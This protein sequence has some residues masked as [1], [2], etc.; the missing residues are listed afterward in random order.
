MGHE[1]KS[2]KTFDSY[3][4]ESVRYFNRHPNLDAQTSGEQISLKKFQKF[5]AVF[6][7]GFAL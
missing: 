3:L 7:L 5:P 1:Q 4:H 6:C 2:A